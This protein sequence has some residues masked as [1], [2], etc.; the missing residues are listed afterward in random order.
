MKSNKR[1]EAEIEAVGKVWNSVPS[2]P[3]ELA[4]EVAAAI[5]HTLRWA[6]GFRE[7][8]PQ[9]VLLRRFEKAR[10]LPGAKL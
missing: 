2:R 3:P 10:L 8:C 7:P 4:E 1:I 5:Y 9:L 6:R